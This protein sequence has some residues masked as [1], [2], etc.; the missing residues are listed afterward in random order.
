M[1]RRALIF[2]TV[3]SV[4]NK[5]P[6]PAPRNPRDTL[7]TAPRARVLGYLEDAPRAMTV[8]DAAADL[9]QHPN[10]LREHLDGLV[11]A[12]LARRERSEPE[13]RGRPSWRYS[14]A[15]ERHETDPR[16]LDYIGLATA[17]ATQIAL[18]STDPRA[19]ALTAG[20]A[21]G[22]ALID[23]SEVTTAVRA[24]RCVVDLLDAWGF[25]PS[26]D[27]RCRTVRLRRCPLLEAARAQ[28]DVICT[29]HLGLVRGVLSSLGVEPGQPSLAPFAE[30][31]A[32]VLRFDAEVPRAAG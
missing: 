3:R 7:L 5:G 21:W 4:K 6:A 22:R 15:P 14:P 10:T 18:T 27:A 26:A 17:L 32:C 25:A 19:D 9:G 20:E 13:G 28:P 31:D 1:G 30:E 24:R 16:V 2:T 11:E 12:G 29:V 23:D 8:G